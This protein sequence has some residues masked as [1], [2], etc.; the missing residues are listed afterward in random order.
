MSVSTPSTLIP[1][2][3]SER[4]LIFL[5]GCVQ[6]INIL[7]FMMVM[8][9]GP[10]LGRALQI[11]NSHMGWIGG[12]YTVAAAVSGMVCSLFLDRAD[13]RTALLWSLL[14]LI[15]S[16]ALGGLA[17]GLGSLL[18]ARML[19]GSF[20][21]PATALT[22]AI[23]ADMVPPER[24]GK[25][26]G[27]LAGAFSAASVLGVPIGLELARWGGWQYPFFAVALAGVLVIVGVRQVLPSMRGHLNAAHPVICVR[28]L[29]KRRAV[30]LSLIAVATVM[31]AQ[32][33]LVPN[34]SAFFQFNL[35]VPREHLGM[36]YCAGGAVS[37]V[38]MRLAGRLTD[39]LGATPISALGTVAFLTVLMI[40]LLPS[41]ALLPPILMFVLFMVT[42]TFRT[43]PMQ[44]MLSRVPTP[45]E[46]A[47]LMSAQSAVQH[48]AA[49]MGA[50]L[51]SFWLTETPSGA[52]VGMDSFGM[53]AAA[54]AAGLPFLLW[55]INMNLVPL[56]PR[57]P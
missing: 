2:G 3:L 6:F 33:A 20:G 52:L 44:A 47:R 5:L 32:F 17:T 45:P 51:S 18:A 48:L 54:V 23:V 27:A 36:L 39:R 14:G 50:G 12:S 40:L 24:R 42:S 10:D 30:V 22:L 29:L 56:T 25:A 13:R 57:G 11:P 41:H 1:A 31:G 53:M 26:M 28:T 16:T 4:K 35:H 49:A 7:D 46:R 21:G 38:T 8:P 43:I 19:A 9:L 15:A 37:F 34:L 55:R